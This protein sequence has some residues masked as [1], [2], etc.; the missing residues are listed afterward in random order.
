VLST[1]KL[2]NNN[3]TKEDIFDFIAK[4]EKLSKVLRIK[5]KDGEKFIEITNKNNAKVFL[6]LLNDEFVYSQLT[7]QK[8]QAANKDER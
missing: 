6:E 4:D 8:Y 5:E 7:N 1:S 2:L 3:V